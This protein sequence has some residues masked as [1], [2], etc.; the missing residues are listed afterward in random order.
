MGNAFDTARSTSG[1]TYWHVALNGGV[2][3]AVWIG[4]AVN[5]VRLC[6]DADPDYARL[7]DLLGITV[8]ADVMNGASAG[9]IN[10]VFLALGL[11]YGRH[12]LSTLRDIWIYSG[13]FE[14]LLRTRSTR[15]RPSLVRG[16]DFFLPEIPRAILGRPTPV[17][18]LT[19]GRL[20]E[21][22]ICKQNRSNGKANQATH[23]HSDG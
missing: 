23:I 10:S 21:Q 12:D 22:G 6:R 18:R 3:L 8:R 17:N 13:S 20:V 2:S 15:R 7:K 16:D 5:E 1:C 14:E 11:L 9:G 4:G 19:I